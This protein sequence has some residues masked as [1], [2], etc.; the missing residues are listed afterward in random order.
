MASRSVRVAILRFLREEEVE[1]R[2][3]MMAMDGL[4]CVGIILSEASC[5]GREPMRD[6]EALV[7]NRVELDGL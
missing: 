1:G 6:T 4:L 5:A 3:G 7:F 2:A